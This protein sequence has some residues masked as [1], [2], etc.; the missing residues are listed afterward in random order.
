M[1]EPKYPFKAKCGN[2]GQD[3]FVH[4]SK[5]KEVEYACNTFKSYEDFHAC[6][7]WKKGMKLV[8][9]EQKPPTPEPSKPVLQSADQLPVV[10]GKVVK[11]NL[12]RTLSYKYG[13]AKEYGVEKEDIFN[14]LTY[15]VEVECDI[16]NLP[17]LEQLQTQTKKHIDAVLWED[18]LKK[19]KLRLITGED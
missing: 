14:S 4:W 16:D 18:F 2:C 12:S 9:I 3:I 11:I 8:M 7:N 1:T 15:G 17:V 13:V 5:K 19:R 6:P 10:K